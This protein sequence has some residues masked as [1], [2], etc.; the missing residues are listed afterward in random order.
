[1]KRLLACAASDFESMSGKDLV[2]SIKAS[3]GRTILAETVVTAAPLLEGISN[4]EVMAA[5]GADL[6]CMNEFDV[7]T[8]EIVG[9]EGID[10]PIQQLKEW[11][12]RPIGINLEPVN[13]D[14]EVMDQK[15]TISNGRQATPE[16]FEQARKLG[17]D[18][19]MI[20]ANPS[21]GVTN[22]GILNSISTAIEHYGGPIFA[23]KMHGAGSDEPVVQEDLLIEIIEKGADGVLIPTVGTVPGITIEQTR[24]IT[25]KIHKLG[26]LV[27]NTIGTSQE[28][29]DEGT[30]RQFALNNKQV[31][32]DIHHIGDGGYG[33]MA[34]PEN[35]TA[36][37]IAIRGKRH[38]FARMA[39][40]IKR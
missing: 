36:F 5:F 12:G 32:A 22:Q 28:S 27:M 35:I 17:I 31:G 10:N 9:M 15:V 2:R 33:R 39:R 7:F 38:T 23:G 40:S 25:E 3:E 26:G 30:I 24:Q 19:I 20:T 16:A 34:P 14:D 21:T 4:G 18:F 11:T 1:M 37:S 8:Q 29:A 6:L 13:P